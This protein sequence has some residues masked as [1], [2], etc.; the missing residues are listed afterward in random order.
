MGVATNGRHRA[1]ALRAGLAWERR[2]WRGGALD[3]AGVDEAGRGAWAGPLVAAAVVLPRDPHERARI[4]RELTRAETLA[5]DSKQLTAVQRE[6]ARSVIVRLGLAHAIAVVPVDEIDAH[7]LG[8]ANREALTRAVQALDPAPDHVLVDALRL[9]H[10]PC[11]YDAIIRGDC[12]SQAIALASILAKFHRDEIMFA[13]HQEHPEYGFARHKGYGTRFH[14]AAL[15]RLGP[16]AHHRRSFAP[17]ASR[18][19]DVSDAR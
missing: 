17:V 8:T 11:T 13:L 9:R 6:M 14:A 5:C 7:G 12:L 1:G 19:R 10:L 3:V 15:D 2:A 16:S 18:C 4:T